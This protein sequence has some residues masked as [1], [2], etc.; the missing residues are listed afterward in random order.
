MTDVER[1]LEQL[2]AGAETLSDEDR[3][4][5]DTAIGHMAEYFETALKQI[6]DEAAAV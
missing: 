2:H 5:V 4:I 3:E 6:R 1:A